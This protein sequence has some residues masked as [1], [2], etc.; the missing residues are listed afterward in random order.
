NYV[1][2]KEI[3][4]KTE[5]K[6]KL[7]YTK[8]RILQTRFVILHLLVDSTGMNEL[9]KRN[10][11]LTFCLVKQIILPNFALANQSFNTNG[12]LSRDDL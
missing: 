4:R 10:K 7:F 1:D 2:T 8:V 11:N 6:I 9:N 12:R 5:R 3:E